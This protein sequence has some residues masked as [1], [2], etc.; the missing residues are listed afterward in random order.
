M[1]DELFETTVKEMFDQIREYHISLGYDYSAITDST[2]MMKH[3]R[4][5]A[6]ALFM[7]MAEV[8]DSMPWKPWRNIESQSVD[9]DNVQREIVDCLFFIGAIMEM[10]HITPIALLD[11]F[12][13]ILKQNYHRIKSG[14]NNTK[15]ERR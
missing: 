5:N 14:Y 12:D 8:V 10:L 9:I 11:K 15:E 1:A 3:F 13:I 2:E 4:E 7:E 6:L